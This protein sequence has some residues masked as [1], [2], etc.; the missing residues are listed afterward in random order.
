MYSAEKIPTTS[1]TTRIYTR[2]RLLVHFG[3]SFVRLLVYFGPFSW[4]NSFCWM[5]RVL[6]HSKKYVIISHN[7]QLIFFLA[8]RNIKLCVWKIYDFWSTLLNCWNR[9]NYQQA[10]FITHQYFVETG[11]QCFR[12][13]AN[14]VYYFVTS[15]YTCVLY[16]YILYMH[17]LHLNIM[18]I[19]TS[20]TGNW[21]WRSVNC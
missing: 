12:R 14:T 2:T 6:E 1:Y 7:K 8:F 19:F 11:N 21:F 20:S 17:N 13:T 15:Q 4:S 18:S 3:S 9:V 10:L 5:F 16:V